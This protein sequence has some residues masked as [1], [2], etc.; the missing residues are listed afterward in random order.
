MSIYTW[1]NRTT[2]VFR[3]ILENFVEDVRIILVTGILVNEVSVVHMDENNNDS[4]Q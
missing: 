4:V 3:S 2:Q 1:T